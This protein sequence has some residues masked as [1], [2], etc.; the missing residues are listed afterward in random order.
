MRSP[1][2]IINDAG[3]HRLLRETL[4]RQLAATPLLLR[5]VER[6]CLWDY[7]L[8]HWHA[9]H[10]GLGW[11]DTK[12]F[13]HRLIVNWLRHEATNYD[14]ILDHLYELPLAATAKYLLHKLLKQHVLVTIAKAYPE[15]RDACKLQARETRSRTNHFRKAA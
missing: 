8:L 12:D 5:A 6:A 4:Q 11:T 2:K 14:D 7:A 10:A 9:E 3:R 13:R 15:L 1:P